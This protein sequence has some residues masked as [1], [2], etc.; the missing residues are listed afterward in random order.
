MA[1]L[2]D[3]CEDRPA[4]EGS[5]AVIRSAS[6]GQH[7]VN[8]HSVTSRWGRPPLRRLLLVGVAALVPVLAGC[9]AGNN[10]PTLN[11][12]PPTD[13]ATAAAG[14]LKILNVFVLGTPLGSTLAPGQN[15]SLFFALSN[16]R[17][18]DRLVS[19]TA[20]GTATSV[21]LPA[22]GIPIGT[23]TTVLLTG[24]RARAYLVNLTRPVTNGSN[25]K[26]VMHFLKE[27]AVTIEVPVFA[28]AAHYV[29]YAP[30]PSPTPTTGKHHHGSA[31][32]SASATPSPS[33]S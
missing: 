32:P 29:T 20:P 28:R 4:Q 31:S 19:I 1:T 27:G 2:S 7:R 21:R 17:M 3:V 25:I 24:P 13:A 15:A 8:Q 26:L 6:A 18:P 12:H 5:T 9:E 23:S 30:A 11:F 10:A 14:N 22:G 33:A 16:T